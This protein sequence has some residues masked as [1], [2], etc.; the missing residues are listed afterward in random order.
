MSRKRKGRN[1]SILQS[2]LIF[3]AP[4]IVL[5]ASII[6]AFL[7]ANNDSPAKDD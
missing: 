3:I 7:T 1:E 2:F 6:V 5:V 4:F